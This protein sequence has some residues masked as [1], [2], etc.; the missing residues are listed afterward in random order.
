VVVT[1]PEMPWV[2]APAGIQEELRD[3]GAYFERCYAS[4]LP[5]IGDVPLARIVSDIRRVGI[6]ST[7]LATDCGAATIPAPV[8]GMR[9][10]RAA[11]LAEGFSERDMRLMAGET[12]ARLLGLG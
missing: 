12:P 9:S 6:E 4:T 2:D 10:Y 3:L 5:G 1:H 7:V 8:A 11:L